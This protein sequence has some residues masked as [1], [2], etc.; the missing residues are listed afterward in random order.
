MTDFQEL[1]FW[2]NHSGSESIVSY[3]EYLGVGCRIR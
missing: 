3:A 2:M 1:V